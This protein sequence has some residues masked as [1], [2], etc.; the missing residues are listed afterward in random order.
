MATSPPSVGAKSI[1]AAHA[2][3][4]GWQIEIGVMPTEPDRIIV[5]TDTVG[6]SPNPKW[7]P[8]RRETSATETTLLIARGNFTM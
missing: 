1:I 6:L 4:S 2:A 8:S 3:I 5:I 7:M